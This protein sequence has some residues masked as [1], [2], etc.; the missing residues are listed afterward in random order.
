M[1]NMSNQDYAISSVSY[2]PNAPNKVS[3]KP[4][5]LVSLTDSTAKKA[6]I[7]YFIAMDRPDPQ[8]GFVAVKGF[9]CDEAKEDI[10]ASFAEIVANTPKE[11]ILELMIPIHRVRC[12]RSLVF[13]ANKAAAPARQER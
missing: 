8:N 5:Y 12:I 4:N 1:N 9:F 13:N 2:D 6:A 7:T 3:K 10:I 11:S